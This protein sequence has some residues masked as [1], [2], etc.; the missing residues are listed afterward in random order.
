MIVDATNIIIFRKRQSIDIDQF[1]SRIR[2]NASKLLGVF[3]LDQIENCKFIF[4][5]ANVVRDFQNIFGI[6]HRVL[7][8]EHQLGSKSFLESRGK[9]QV[10]ADCARRAFHDE[11]IGFFCT[12]VLEIGF[13]I[14]SIKH[15]IHEFYV[16][17]GFPL[18]KRR[19]VGQFPGVITTIGE[20]LHT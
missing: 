10:F 19:G 6:G 1:A 20:I 4:T 11:P 9:T 3:S 18:Q 5:D 17:V 14:P 15:T 16:M 8:R 2:M 7:P 13:K 12:G